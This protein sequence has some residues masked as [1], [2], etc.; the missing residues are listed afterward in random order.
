[1]SD[2]KSILFSSMSAA[3][4]MKSGRVPE[5]STYVFSHSFMALRVASLRWPRIMGSFGCLLAILVMSP[6]EEKPSPV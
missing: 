1:M 3:S 5:V 2:P 6:G 4:S